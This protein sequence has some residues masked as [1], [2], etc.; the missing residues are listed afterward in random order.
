M[1]WVK[2]DES[3]LQSQEICRAVK[4]NKE[5]RTIATEEKTKQTEKREIKKWQKVQILTVQQRTEILS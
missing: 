3:H 1:S 4:Q 5:H 2:W